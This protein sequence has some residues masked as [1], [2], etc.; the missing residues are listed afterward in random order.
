MLKI[1]DP[2]DGRNTH[3]TAHLYYRF[4]ARTGLRGID[5]L[6]KFIV[7]PM[8]MFD[9]QNLQCKANA[10]DEGFVP[11]TIAEKICSVRFVEVIPDGK[12]STKCYRVS[13]YDLP[14]LRRFFI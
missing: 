14:M 1:C 11:F 4:L 8:R 6:R 5:E 3:T 2:I 9:C 13:K 10:L 7:Q 12:V